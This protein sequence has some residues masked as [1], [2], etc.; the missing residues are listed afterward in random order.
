LSQKLLAEV[1]GALSPDMAD[2]KPDPN[3][4]VNGDTFDDAGVY[5]LRGDL[6]LVQTVD[7]FTPIV[8]DPYEF[9]QIAAANALSDVYAMGGRP[10]TALNL[11]GVP[12]DKLNPRDIA[13]ILRGGAEK[14]REAGCALVGGHTIKSSEPIYGLSVTGIVHPRH[15]LTNAAAC[16]GDLLV[17]T[18]PLGTGII[19]TGIQRG[20]APASIA[21]AAIRQM[22][23]LNTIGAE[24]A[25]RQLTRC[26][27][28]IT[29]FGLTGHLGNILRASSVAAEITAAAV[30]VIG[31]QV[32]D[33][34][35]KKCIPGGTMANLHSADAFVDWGTT[36][37]DLRI[38][39]ADAQTS[40][41]LLLCV[42][43]RDLEHVLQCLDQDQALSKAVIG[44]IVSGEPA[45]RV[46]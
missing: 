18:K 37:D 3:V 34:I 12:G 27:T 17:L 1:L 7:F 15:I 44:K 40:G 30:P 24:L 29:G 11:L 45:I 43:P 21:D 28:D 42:N 10:I 9:G 26:A 2:R 23:R 8:D 31:A 4:L 41:P 46:R 16:P 22:I 36:P 35:A 14:V 20:L 5:Q 25:E 32:M 38:V 33:L 39:L 6:A 13:G 19:T